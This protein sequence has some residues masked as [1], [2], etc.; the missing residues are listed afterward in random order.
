ME[1]YEIHRLYQA[2]RLMVAHVHGTHEAVVIERGHFSLRE[3]M[4]N[5][6][7][8]CLGTPPSQ[9]IKFRTLLHAFPRVAQKLYPN[10]HSNAVLGQHL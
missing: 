5:Y 8:E 7:F 9:A 6:E 3:K 10:E 2:K 1:L 4:A